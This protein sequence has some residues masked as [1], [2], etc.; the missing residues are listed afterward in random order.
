[1][2]TNQPY[3]IEKFLDAVAAGVPVRRAGRL[4]LFTPSTK[5]TMALW[6]KICEELGPQ[7]I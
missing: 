5:A 6:K 3:H 2:L 1:M 4:H 7:A